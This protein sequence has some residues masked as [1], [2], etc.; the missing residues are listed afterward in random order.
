MELMSNRTEFWAQVIKYWIYT[1]PFFVVYAVGAIA[2]L[3]HGGLSMRHTRLV[4]LGCVG[5]F[6]LS[7]VMPVAMNYFM[8]AL[9][10]RGEAAYNSSFL[11]AFSLITNVLLAVG[12]SLILRAAFVGRSSSCASNGT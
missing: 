12:L 7:L 4:F 6:L 8:W 3:R 2:A 1:S 9:Y 10:A 5:S 11:D